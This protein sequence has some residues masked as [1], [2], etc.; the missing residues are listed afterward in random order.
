MMWEEILFNFVHTRFINL[1]GCRS[2]LGHVPF[3]S[4]L[5]SIFLSLHV[6]DQWSLALQVL[7]TLLWVNYA[8]SKMLT[9]KWL[10]SVL[11]L[12]NL[13]WKVAAEPQIIRILKLGQCL[14]AHFLRVRVFIL[15]PY[16]LNPKPPFIMGSFLSDSV[17]MVG[18]RWINGMGSRDWDQRLD[19]IYLQTPLV[20]S[21]LVGWSRTSKKRWTLGIWL[22]KSLGT[23]WSLEGQGCPSFVLSTWGP[24]QLSFFFS[25]LILRAT[26]V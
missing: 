11:P 5:F 17:L 25:S 15:K 14:C 2:L 6:T 21:L 12:P 7:S 24:L 16:T 23:P 1:L 8:F 3:R 19:M 4:C 18:T 13:L 26:I 20:P 9:W 10:T 22:A